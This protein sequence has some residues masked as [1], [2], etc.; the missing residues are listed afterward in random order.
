MHSNI[1]LMNKR[2][3]QL[4]IFLV[5]IGSV[6]YLILIQEDHLGVCYKYLCYYNRYSSGTLRVSVLVY[7]VLIE[8]HVYII[9]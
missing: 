6:S 1:L 9:Y 8:S 7:A 5:V 2:V 3:Y 4:D